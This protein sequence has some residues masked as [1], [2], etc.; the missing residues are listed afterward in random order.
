MPDKE[1]PF[2]LITGRRREHYNNG[3]MT[4][5]SE[6]IM[7]LWPEETLEIN[8]DD[9]KDLKVFDGEYVNLISRRGKV[10]IKTRITLRAK[11]GR[12]FTSFHYI[13]TLTNLVTNSVFDPIAGTPEYKACAVKV[14]KVK[15]LTR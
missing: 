8:P 13:K 4:T 11:K 1:F 2:I 14:E 10:K 7:E 9:A 12:F 6:G 3:S 15:A 5:R